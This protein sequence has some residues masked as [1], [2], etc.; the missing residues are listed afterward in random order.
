M[1]LD[2]QLILKRFFCRNRSHRNHVLA[3]LKLHGKALFSKQ[4]LFN[5]LDFTSQC[6]DQIRKIFDYLTPFMA[7]QRAKLFTLLRW[8][9]A[10]SVTSRVQL[11]SGHNLFIL[12]FKLKQLSVLLFNELFLLC[13]IVFHLFERVLCRGDDVFDTGLIWRYLVLRLHLG[14]W[15]SCDLLKRLLLVVV[16]ALVGLGALVLRGAGFMSDATG[17]PDELTQTNRAVSFTHAVHLALG[18]NRGFINELLLLL[19]LLYLRLGMLL[20][21]GGRQVRIRKTTL[22]LLSQHVDLDFVVAFQEADLVFKALYGTVDSRVTFITF[23]CETLLQ[24]LVLLLEQFKD[25]FLVFQLR[26][27]SLCHL[28]KLSDVRLHVL[29]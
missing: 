19:S 11:V 17:L 18:S 15:D 29:E 20:L 22:V 2:V 24:R 4:A 8:S 13:Q 7:L 10:A 28:L 23:G 5:A 6:F 9:I 16:L 12:N 26:L 25:A 14:H 21:L 1:H 27:Q 3:V